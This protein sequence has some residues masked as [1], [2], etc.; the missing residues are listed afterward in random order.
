MEWPA[1]YR[2]GL[3]VLGCLLSS[4][5]NDAVKLSRMYGFSWQ[6]NDPIVLSAAVEA[7]HSVTGL[8]YR[9]VDGTYLR[10]TIF[11]FGFPDVIHHIAQRG[12][13]SYCRIAIF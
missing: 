11:T 8:A 13:R 1:W 10:I 7:Y 2:C 3:V 6:K 5:I 9:Y 4:K 12:P